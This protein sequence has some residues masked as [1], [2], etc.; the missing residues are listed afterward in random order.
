M[1]D[2]KSEPR[3]SSG[4]RSRDVKDTGSLIDREKLCPF[5]LKMYYCQGQQSHRQDMFTPT[6]TPPQSEELRLYTWK[7]ATLGEIAS[8]VKQAVP[9]E[10]DQAGPEGE[11]IFRHYFLDPAQGHYRGRDVGV[12]FLTG[13][14]E[15]SSSDA[16]DNNSTSQQ[17]TQPP[18][19]I[20]I[21]E[22]STSTQKTLESFNFVIGDYL[23][24]A[25][26]STSNREGR[27][28]NSGGIGAGG[29][30]GG[31]RGGDFGGRRDDRRRRRDDR[32]RDRYRG[33]KRPRLNNGHGQG[34]S[35]RFGVDAQNEPSWKSR[36]RGR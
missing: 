1:A 34:Y 33:E 25:F 8:L 24:I 12:I 22:R 19:T 16:T 5:L 28:R 11:M 17:Q 9:H 30:G 10:V 26:R 27:G 36:G 14:T 15:T 23:D 7:N 13:V 29:G 4:P 2:R 18:S 31:G 20:S 35:G 21:S 32:D 6:S 3:D